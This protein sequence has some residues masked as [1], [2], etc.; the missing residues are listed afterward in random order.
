[1]VA[2]ISRDDEPSGRSLVQRRK[3][4]RALSRQKRLSP[5]CAYITWTA[6]QMKKKIEQ[7]NKITTEEVP[8]SDQSVFARLTHRSWWSN[9]PSARTSCHRWVLRTPSRM[10]AH[11]AEWTSRL[12]EVYLGRLRAAKLLCAWASPCWRFRSELRSREGSM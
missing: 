6:T 4:A 9:I 3:L 11:A 8:E 12:Q 2:Q 1:M 5:P 10:F 7:I